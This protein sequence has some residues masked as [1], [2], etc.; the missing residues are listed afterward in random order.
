[1]KRTEYSF[2][3]I[4]FNGSRA[5]IPTKVREL[6]N[7][8]Y[9]SFFCTRQFAQS[10][11]LFAE[12]PIGCQPYNGMHYLH[13]DTGPKKLVRDFLKKRYHFSKSR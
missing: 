12:K 1:M 7:L 2:G 8:V 6:I 4:D 9:G 10:P 13:R 11:A 3:K 5:V